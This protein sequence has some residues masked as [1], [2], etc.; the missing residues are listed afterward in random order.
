MNILP[1]LSI[2]YWEEVTFTLSQDP[3]VHTFY[4]RFPISN[5][6]FGEKKYKKIIL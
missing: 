5:L 1:Q 4:V 2:L 3:Y 6:H